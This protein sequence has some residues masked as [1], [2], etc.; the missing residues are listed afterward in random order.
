MPWTSSAAV[1]RRSKARGRGSTWPGPCASAG[2][3]EAAR[4]E[5]RA[6]RKAFGRLGAAHGLELAARLL[7]GFVDEAE[8]RAPPP[9]VNLTARE[10]EVLRALVAGFTNR[11]IAVRLVISEHTVHRHVT[12]LYR[13]LGVSSRTAAAAYAHRHE[14]A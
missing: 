5:V 3:P 4:D 2:R 14:L 9:A 13:K 11:E 12:N 8:A 6:A 10:L 7:A 1:A